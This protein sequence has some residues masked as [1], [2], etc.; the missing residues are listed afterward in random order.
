MIHCV[1]WLLFLCV[2]VCVRYGLRCSF[3]ASARAATDLSDVEVFSSWLHGAPGTLSKLLFF[4]YAA[5]VELEVRGNEY[6]SAEVL[7]GGTHEVCY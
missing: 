6:S 7:F 4:L 2:Y 5:G 3:T 1:L